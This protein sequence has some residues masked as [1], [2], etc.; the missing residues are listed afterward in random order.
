MGKIE[1]KF[2]FHH[3]F[4]HF[5]ID[6]D[7]KFSLGE[8]KNVTKKTFI[9]NFESE[10]DKKGSLLC[11][12]ANSCTKIEEIIALCCGKMHIEKMCDEHFKQKK[13]LFN[14]LIAGKKVYS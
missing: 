5:P 9:L 11:K 6:L 3:I 7:R 2:I 1:I 4:P 10:T 8:Q 13:T 12:S 14:Q